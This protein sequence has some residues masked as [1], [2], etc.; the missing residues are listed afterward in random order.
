MESA[1]LLLH[2]GGGRERGP[3]RTQG[4]FARRHDPET[5]SFDVVSFD[6]R[7]FPAKTRDRAPPERTPPAAT[8]P[9]LSPIS[10]DDTRKTKHSTPLNSKR[11]R[12][13]FA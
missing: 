5:R 9:F 4:A 12:R 8:D 1:R 2:L 13:I 11:R 7:S 10:I 6:T 3:H